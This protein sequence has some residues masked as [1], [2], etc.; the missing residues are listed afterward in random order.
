MEDEKG[1]GCREREREKKRAREHPRSGGGQQAC[2]QLYPGWMEHDCSLIHSV[3][4]SLPGRAVFCLV[5]CALEAAEIP[6]GSLGGCCWGIP[7]GVLLL[8][9]QQEAGWGRGSLSHFGESQ[10]RALGHRGHMQGLLLFGQK[11]VEGAILRQPSAQDTRIFSSVH[12]K[13]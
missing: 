6:P 1:R 11:G 3:T 9:S 10:K 2:T 4:G 5:I 13:A 8:W 7:A 12:L